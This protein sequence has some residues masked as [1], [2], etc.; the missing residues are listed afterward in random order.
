[1]QVK[2]DIEA[3]NVVVFT[4]PIVDQEGNVVVAEGEVLTSDLMS[5]VDWFVEGVIGSPK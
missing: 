2:G 3:G 1:M 5:S 4:G